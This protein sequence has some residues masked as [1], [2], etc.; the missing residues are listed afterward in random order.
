MVFELL[1]TIL[2]LV[3]G[4]FSCSEHCASKLK[5]L[6]HTKPPLARQL[7][8][9][10]LGLRIG[11]KRRPQRENLS[12]NMKYMEMTRNL[13]PFLRV[14]ISADQN[15]CNYFP[16]QFY[17]ANPFR[18]K[19]QTFRVAR[20]SVTARKLQSDLLPATVV[21]FRYIRHPKTLPSRYLLYN[22][23]MYVCVCLLIVRI[24]LPIVFSFLR[25]D[26]VADTYVFR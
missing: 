6:I 22:D 1:V 2:L 19:A 23:Y 15:G 7:E 17:F 16:S 21:D 13:H 3:N 14:Y 24:E 18:R 4:Q 11:G 25:I 12:L 9:L 20:N 5:N 8:N 26:R 10:S